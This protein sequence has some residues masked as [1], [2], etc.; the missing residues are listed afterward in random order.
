[1]ETTDGGIDRPGCSS[2]PFVRS[3]LMA[4]WKV[5][6]SRT[7]AGGVCVWVHFRILADQEAK[8]PSQV[9]GGRRGLRKCRDRRDH[10]VIIAEKQMRPAV[11]ERATCGL[12]SKRERGVGKVLLGVHT[13]QPGWR[14]WSTVRGNRHLATTSKAG[15]RNKHVRVA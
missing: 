8:K 1:M 11:V 14:V 4:L 10:E 13:L 2:L 7:G 6:R 9:G 3:D 5:V 12:L 15:V